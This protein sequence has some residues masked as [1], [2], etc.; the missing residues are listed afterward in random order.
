ML[1]N[2][3]VAGIGGA[4]CAL[5]AMAGTPNPFADNNGI[6]PS[7]AE[8]DGPLFKLSY[9][10][11]SH[12]P[13]PAMPWRAV[14]GDQAISVQTAPAVAQAMKAAVAADMRV[15]LFD[16][17]NWN[18]E[19]RGWYNQP[20]LGAETEAIHGTHVGTAFFAPSLFAQSGLTKPMSSYVI[21]YFDRTAAQTLGAIW[22][23]P[24]K[25]TL[26][27]QTTQYAEGSIIV[28][29]AFVTA[30]GAAWPPMEGAATWPVYITTNA[31]TGQFDKPTVTRVSLMQIDIIVKD[32]KAS[33][34][35]G[36]IFTTLVY[37]KDVKPGPNG[38]WD[39]MVPLG[40]QWGNDPDVN[41]EP[42]PGAALSENWNN[43]QAPLYAKETLGWGERLSGP[44]DGAVSDLSVQFD[45]GR[46][47][48]PAHRSS[49]CMSCHGSAQWDARDPGK[50]M[51][52]FLMPLAPTNGGE[53]YLNAPAP[54]SSEWLRWFQNRTGDVP[55]DAGSV[56]AD[57]DLTLTFK[58]LPNWFKAMTGKDAQA[59]P[60]ATGREYNGQTR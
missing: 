40:A 13:T 14:L 18:A 25:P 15:L 27:T 26:S 44:N 30:D 45:S 21:T 10:Y 1:I 37:D 58:V 11:P 60:K 47:L 12:L 20:W 41:S 46:Q 59:K 9:K 57:F 31:S 6:N 7:S 51:A 38:V 42:S 43:P 4:L 29:A 22:K 2:R 8:Y 16:Y 28:K 5:S 36:W 54:G 32:S 34:K 19:K 39:Q 55:M 23:S 3:I 17:A 48:L 24:I 56:A 53:P 52:S 50:G 35:T 33:P 49:S